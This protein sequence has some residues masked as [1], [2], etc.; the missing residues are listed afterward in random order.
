MSEFAL[1]VVQHELRHMSCK[2]FIVYK[3]VFRCLMDLLLTS[4]FQ[5]P[6]HFFFSCFVRTQSSCGGVVIQFEISQLWANLKNF[7]SLTQN[8]F[9]YVRILES[10]LSVT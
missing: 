1:I 6:F 10:L 4:D 2:S 7:Y 5:S 3:T 9:F 8:T